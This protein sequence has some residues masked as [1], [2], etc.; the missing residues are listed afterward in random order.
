[1]ES[2]ESNERVGLSASGRRSDFHSENSGSI[3]G[4]PTINV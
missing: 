1:M 4:S 2:D 3:P